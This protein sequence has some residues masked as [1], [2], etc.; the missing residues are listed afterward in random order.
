MAAAVLAM[1]EKKDIQGLIKQGYG[2]LKHGKY[3][4][5]QLQDPGDFQH[6]LESHIDSITPASASK[7]TQAISLAFTCEGLRTLGLP[8]DSLATFSREWR[9]SMVTPERSARL[10]DRQH[11]DP[12]DW[13]WGAPHQERI[14]ILLCGFFDSGKACNDWVGAIRKLTFLKEIRALDTQQLPHSKEHF[15]FRDGISQPAIKGL[16]NAGEDFNAIEPGEFI[17]GYRNEYDETP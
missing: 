10:G 5:L 9:E 4:L 16:H 15:G 1:I 11:N 2:Y 6:W 7:P 17:L 14:D 8:E 13:L 3:L 12:N